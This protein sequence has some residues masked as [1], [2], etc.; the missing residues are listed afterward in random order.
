[1]PYNQVL[2][3]ATPITGNENF[4]ELFQRFRGKIDENSF[5]ERRK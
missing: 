5:S 2:Y 3:T 4:N 1:M